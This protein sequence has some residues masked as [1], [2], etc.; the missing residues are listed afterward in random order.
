MQYTMPPRLP[1]CRSREIGNPAKAKRQDDVSTTPCRSSAG[2]NPVLFIFPVIPTRVPP[3]EGWDRNPA[4]YNP[5]TSSLHHIITSSPY[6]PLHIYAV[7]CLCFAV[8]CKNTTNTSH[9]L[10]INYTNTNV[11]QC[12]SRLFPAFYPGISR[13]YARRRVVVIRFISSVF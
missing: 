10:Y 5:L 13:E 9:L 3:S 1:P 12:D 4:H 11:L 7:F 6:N 2:W 8:F